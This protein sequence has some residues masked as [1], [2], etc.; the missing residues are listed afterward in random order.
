[1]DPERLLKEKPPGVSGGKSVICQKY[2][3]FMF[4]NVRSDYILYY[5]LNHK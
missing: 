5:D 1:M 3:I 4:S 2:E